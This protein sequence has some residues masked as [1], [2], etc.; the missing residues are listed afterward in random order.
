MIKYNP[1]P[2]DQRAPIDNAVMALACLSAA[3]L[4]DAV[5]SFNALFE[6]CHSKPKL[7]VEVAA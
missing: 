3:D 7:T 2:V 4:A 1:K 6:R 5:A